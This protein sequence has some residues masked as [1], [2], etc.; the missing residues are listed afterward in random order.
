MSD[1]K[2]PEKL[3]SI[4][5]IA[6]RRDPNMTGFHDREKDKSAIGRKDLAELKAELEAW[7]K[8]LLESLQNRE[9]FESL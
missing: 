6:K 2:N 5:R 1:E 7:I 4:H 8:N 3:P 9:S